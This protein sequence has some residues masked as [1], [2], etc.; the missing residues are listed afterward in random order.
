MADEEEEEEPK[1]T[2]ILGQALGF[3]EIFEACETI[4][5]FPFFIYV[6]LGLKLKRIEFQW[7]VADEFMIF[8]GDKANIVR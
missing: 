6:I 4:L 1:T 8:V 3:I 5:I 7:Q 2:L